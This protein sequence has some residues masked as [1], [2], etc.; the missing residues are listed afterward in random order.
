MPKTFFSF[1][2]GSTSSDVP[3]DA[4]AEVTQCCGTRSACLS[5]GLCA[6]DSTSSDSGISYARGTCTDP[7]WA[8][9]SCPQRCQLNQ[10]TPTNS[11]VYDF[12][13]GGVQVWAC[14]GAQGYGK[15]AEYCCESAAE[16]TRCCSTETAVFTL[17]AASVGP[18]VG[19]LASTTASRAASL[20]VT[21]VS[22]VASRT[23]G[24]ASQAISSTSRFESTSSTTSTAAPPAQQSD[25]NAIRVGAGVGGAI[26][27]CFLVAA[28]VFF[29]QWHKR[30]KN[31]TSS[32]GN[33][34]HGKD[35]AP[36]PVEIDPY[37]QRHE[38]PGLQPYELPT[39]GM[40][41]EMPA[42]G[43]VLESP[44]DRR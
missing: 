39:Q 32:P 36:G 33:N 19:A 40:T 34:L 4:N 20:A 10:D 29:F 1:P 17:A 41:A 28:I 8:S 23:R 26:G 14:G 3:C 27:G 24:V 2:N 35:G 11:S 15:V 31:A 38:L 22:I 25:N 6:L 21:Q 18:S 30:R 43:A 13:A 44:A 16:G 5:N 42:H 37:V 9:L 7:S 12:R